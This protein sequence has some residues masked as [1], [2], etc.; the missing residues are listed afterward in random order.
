MPHFFHWV[1]FVWQSLSILS[2]S[3]IKCFS[4]QFS[5]WSDFSDILTS[6][7]CSVV[8]HL[9]CSCPSCFFLD[10]F[11]LGLLQSCQIGTSL[12]W[13]SGNFF[14]ISWVL[15]FWIPCLPFGLFLHFGFLYYYYERLHGNVFGGI[16]FLSSHLTGCWE[17]SILEIIFLK[18]LE[19]FP[20]CLAAVLMFQDLISKKLFFGQLPGRFEPFHWI[21]AIQQNVLWAFVHCSHIIASCSFFMGYNICYFFKDIIVSLTCS[22]IPCIAFGSSDF[23]LFWSLFVGGFLH[24]CVILSSSFITKR[25][26]QR[27]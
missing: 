2:S 13:H 8:I 4:V 7:M 3:F 24:I 14:H 15:F 11:L 20:Y 12:C 21:L 5:T 1:S 9:F 27:W 26:F 22:S 6:S 19:V 25:K 17:I 23:C 18:S 16:L 10:C